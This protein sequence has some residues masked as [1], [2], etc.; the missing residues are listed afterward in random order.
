MKINTQ[1]LEKI[2]NSESRILVV[3]KYLDK[4][5]TDEVVLFMEKNY[6]DIIE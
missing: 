5:D 1:I 6:F 2:K 4:K 3:T